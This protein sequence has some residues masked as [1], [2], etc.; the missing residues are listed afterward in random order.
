MSKVRYYTR[1]NFSPVIRVYQAALFSIVKYYIFFTTI[2]KN[3]IVF[4]KRKKIYIY[5][6][7]ISLLIAGTTAD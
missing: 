4:S 3:D 2:N 1:V 5:C 7:I 6:A